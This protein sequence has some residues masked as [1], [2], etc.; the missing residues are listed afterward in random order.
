MLSSFTIPHATMR[1]TTMAS[2]VVHS[3]TDP[4]TC[5][6][7]NTAANGWANGHVMEYTKEAKPEPPFAAV[8]F[9]T[10]RK[11]RMISRTDSTYQ[12]I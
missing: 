1:Y 5:V 9:S 4:A 7:P 2:S 3:I 8:A 11:A 10:K 6:R 12:M